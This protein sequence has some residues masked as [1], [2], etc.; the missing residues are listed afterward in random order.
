MEPAEAPPK[1]VA[2]RPGLPAEHE[3]VEAVAP[4]RNQPVSTA[5]ANSARPNE[6]LKGFEVAKDEF[7]V[8]QPEEVAALRPQTSSEL[9]IAE[10]VNQAEI[11]PSIAK[12]LIM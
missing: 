5:G 11:D 7:V 10:F 1:V 6:I 9:E 12:L 8:F 4:A 2:F 3:P